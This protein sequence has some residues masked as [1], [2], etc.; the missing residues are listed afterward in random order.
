MAYFDNAATTFPKPE[1]VYE[2]MQAFYRSSGANAGRG[3][4]ALAQSA[5]ALIRE[6]RALLQELLH[7]PNKQVIFTPTATIALNIVLQG[8]LKIGIRNVY[9]SPFEHNSVTRIL[10]YYI[11]HYGISVHE[12]YVD[13]KFNYDLERIKYQFESSRPELVIVSQASN[14]FGLIAPVEEIFKL[15]KA[16]DSYTVTDMSQTAGLIDTEVGLETFDFAIFAGHKTLYGPMGISGFVMNPGIKLEPILFGGTGF[17]SAN[18]DMPSSLPER[19]EMGT[20]NIMGMAGLKAAL[21]WHREQ[22]I[23]RIWVR[24]LEHRQ[25]LVALL[26]RYDFLRLVGNE[27]GQKYIGIVSCLFNGIS[28][29][30]AGEIFSDRGISVRTG[31][32][33]APLAHKFLGTFPAGTIRFSVSY[34]TSEEDFEE[35]EGAL[36]SIAKDL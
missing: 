22:G 27:P 33:C 2:Y 28:A 6:T 14:V 31:L 34:M 9:I 36:D 3:R 29:D 16:F 25:R 1:A 26:E 11:E 18:Q 32:Q 23:A 5:G 13:E 4:Y 35:L 12:L 21:Q 8:L 17:E 20:G 30:S 15:A 10:H 24:E 19:Y 7:C